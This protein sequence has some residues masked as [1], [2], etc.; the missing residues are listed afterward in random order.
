MID[1]LAKSNLV[2]GFGLA[3]LTAAVPL[4]VPGWRPAV[5]SAIKLGITLV[6]ES[7]AEAEGELIQSLVET[8]IEAICEELAKPVG[9]AER[10]AAVRR[11][12][13]HFKH[14]ARRRSQRWDGDESGHGQFYRRHVVRLEASLRHHQQRATGRDRPIIEAVAAGLAST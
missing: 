9:D 12:L 13:R 5:K 10:E 2:A 4:L 11:H 7:E 6:A 1:E 14:R 8:T 3:I